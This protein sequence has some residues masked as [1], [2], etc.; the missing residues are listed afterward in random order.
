MYTF[1][2]S[3]KIFLPSASSIAL[4]AGTKQQVVKYFSTQPSLPHTGYQTQHIETTLYVVSIAG[5][6][7]YE[8]RWTIRATKHTLHVC[9]ALVQ[10]HLNSSKQKR[11]AQINM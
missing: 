2:S 1:C 8:M 7:M 6:G 10:A 4:S 5:L 3:L 11:T 9:H